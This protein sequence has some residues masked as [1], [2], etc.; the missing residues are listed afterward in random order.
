MGP[1]IF[2]ISHPRSE[3]RA[4]C[5]LNAQARLGLRMAGEEGCGEQP[6]GVRK[7]HVQQPA[8]RRRPDAPGN[9]VLGAETPVTLSQ[10]FF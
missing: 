1:F 10:T 2:T 4:S 6:L 9:R 7:S 8:H 3:L 5:G